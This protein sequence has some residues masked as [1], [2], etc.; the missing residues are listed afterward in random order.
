MIMI[1]EI[2]YKCKLLKIYLRLI[3]YLNSRTIYRTRNILR[4]N[5]LK[6]TIPI[7]SVNEDHNQNHNQNQNQNQNKN[8]NKNQN[9]NHNQNPNSVLN[10]EVK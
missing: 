9:H 10:Y 3:E 8:Q 1:V 7:L 4:L 2:P 5:T 6:I